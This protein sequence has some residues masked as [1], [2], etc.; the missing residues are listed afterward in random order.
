[1]SK[2]TLFT[3]FMPLKDASKHDLVTR[4]GNTY[5]IYGYPVMLDERIT[6]HEAILG[7]FK[8]GYY[9]NM[10]EEVNVDGGFERKTN[11]Y[12][13]LGAAMFDGDVALPKAFV[14]LVKA[15]A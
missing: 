13:Y 3:D 2:K 15:T 10:P 8:A 9:G 11:S 1:M 12:E 4:E 5:F 6:L 14:K 7:D